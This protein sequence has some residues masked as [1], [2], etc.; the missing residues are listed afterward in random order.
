MTNLQGDVI[1]ITTPDG[2]S[3][4]V[5]IYDPFGKP[6]TATGT[7]AAINPLRYRGYYYDTESGLYYLKSRYY[8]PGIC[9]F[10]NADDASMLGA[11]GEF[12]GY[13]LFAYCKDNPINGIDPNGNWNWGGFIAGAGIIA[14]TVLTV[15]TF[16]IATPVAAVVAAA[17]VTTGAVMATAAATDSTMVI[18]ASVSYQKKPGLYVKIG[19]S[20]IVDFDEDGG[21]YSYSHFGG[22]VGKARGLSYSAGIV[23]N[24]SAPE[25]YSGKFFD[26]NGGNT[27]GGDICFTPHDSIE[28]LSKTTNAESFTFSFPFGPSYGIGIDFYSKPIELLTW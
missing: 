1:G 11:D 12:V 9:R 10:I 8:D 19:I 5:Y 26:F 2:E 17:A 28:E 20:V 18:D 14:A 23:N 22:G 3:R 15:A 16:G 13:N 24:F 4:A 25:D 21:I 6:L 27:Y 7:M